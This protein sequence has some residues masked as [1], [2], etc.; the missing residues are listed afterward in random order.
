[1]LGFTNMGLLHRSDAASTNALFDLNLHVCIG[2]A[3]SRHD[4]A[5]KLV[6]GGSGVSICTARLGDI[7]H[8]GPGW[9]PKS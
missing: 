1:M 9:R 2:S 6:L 5:S 7:L 8:L 3:G 4:S